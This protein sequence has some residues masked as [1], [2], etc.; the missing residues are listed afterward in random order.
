MKKTVPEGSLSYDENKSPKHTMME[1]GADSSSASDDRILCGF[2]ISYSSNANGRYWPLHEGRNRIGSDISNDISINDNRVSSN[3]A[4]LNI[5][6]SVN[7]GRLLVAI[8]DQNSSNGTVV[9]GRDIEFTPAE[10]NSGD[11]IKIGSHELV[12]LY[13]DRNAKGLSI[14]EDLQ[15]SKQPKTKSQFT[16]PYDYSVKSN[17]RKPTKPS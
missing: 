5:R 1:G 17:I 13:V 6:H 16:S 2:L 7:D 14:A 9:N 15:A 8:S 10:L 11:V 12:I 3:H 4:I